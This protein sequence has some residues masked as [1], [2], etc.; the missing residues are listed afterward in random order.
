[1]RRQLPV[2]VGGANRGG[3]DDL[4]AQRLADRVS[5]AVR[6]QFPEDILPMKPDGVDG[7][8]EDDA[9]FRVGLAFGAPRIEYRARVC[10]M[11]LWRI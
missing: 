5:T 11:R 9:D 6:R 4:L 3:G 10:S 8:I 7:D 1:V 2:L